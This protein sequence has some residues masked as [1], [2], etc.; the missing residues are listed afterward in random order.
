[1]Q[2]NLTSEQEPERNTTTDQT[3][4]SKPAQAR[5]NPRLVVGNLDYFELLM[6]QEE[7]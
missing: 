4:Q 3:E 6:E 7:I 2:I 5:R 1:M